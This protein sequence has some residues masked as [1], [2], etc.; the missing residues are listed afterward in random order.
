ML[1]CSSGI[2]GSFE[3]PLEGARLLA[4]ACRLAV[5]PWGLRD[6]FELVLGRRFR[7]DGGYQWADLDLADELVPTRQRLVAGAA[8][9]HDV[10]QERVV[11]VG[12]SELEAL[13]HAR[14]A[15]APPDPVLR[16]R[17]AAD[18]YELL[19][20]PAEVHAERV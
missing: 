20:E 15:A 18:R 8:R 11:V 4:D 14:R 6:P 7:V 12:G 10:V 9:E 13:L 19:V 2:S 17:L 1:S 3:P 5:D 16:N